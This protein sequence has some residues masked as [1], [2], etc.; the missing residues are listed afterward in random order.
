MQ[1]S[2]HHGDRWFKDA[3]AQGERRAS[4]DRIFQELQ[5]A[6][7][8][9]GHPIGETGQFPDGAMTPDDKGQLRIAITAQH[10]KV[11][12]AFGQPVEWIGWTAAEA[13]AVAK[14][15]GEWANKA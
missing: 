13:R 11:I 14:A 10:G 5:A 8:A 6:T 1:E 12:L 4:L 9:A 3:F 7:K 15:L 2:E